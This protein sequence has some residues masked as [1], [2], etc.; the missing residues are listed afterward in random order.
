MQDFE[1]CFDKK[2]FVQICWPR[3]AVIFLID[4]KSNLRMIFLNNYQASFVQMW[5]GP[6]EKVNCI[7]VW[8]MRQNPLNPYTV[9]LFFKLEILETCAV[10]MSHVF[11]FKYLFGF[12]HIFLALI[13]Y[14]NLRL[15]KGYTLLNTWHKSSFEILPMPAPQSRTE[16][17]WKV[18]LCPRIFRRTLS[19]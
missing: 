8:Q 5:F 2:F 9:I 4:K 15:W 13:N 12:V 3:N 7:F 19:E 18:G 10:K 1:A 16:P 6:L 14:V 17:L 11:L